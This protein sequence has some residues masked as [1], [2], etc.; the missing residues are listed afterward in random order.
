MCRRIVLLVLLLLVPATSGSASEISKITLS[1]LHTRSDL[2]SMGEVVELVRKADQ[3]LVTIRSDVH[4]KGESSQ[5]TYTFKLVTRGGLKDFDPSL[6]IGDTG[7]FFLKF[8]KEEGPVEK[9]YW[10]SVA[11]F[12]KNH[13]VAAATPPS[14]LV[15]AWRSH[16]VDNGQIRDTDAYE[17]GFRKGYAGPPG[18]VDGAADFNLGHSDGMVAGSN[19]LPNQEDEP[20][21]AAQGDDLKGQ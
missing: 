16:R 7:V 10:G 13:F 4:L 5:T 2:I 21:R 14:A 15:D 20:Y 19:K 18:L 1:E 6:R 12:Q 9:A 11:T 17:R 3:D 8:R